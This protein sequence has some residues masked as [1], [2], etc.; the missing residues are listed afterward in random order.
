MRI[1]MVCPLD[2]A[3][4][5]TAEGNPYRA[6]G[7][8]AAA[9]VADGHQVTLFAAAGS[10]GGSKLV[11]CLGPEDKDLELAPMVR[12]AFQLA[13][14]L[15]AASTFDLVHNHIGLTAAALLS[16]SDLPLLT[17]IHRPCPP[18]EEPAWRWLGQDA[19]FSA[20]YAGAAPDGLPLLGMVSPGPQMAETCLALYRRVLDRRENYRPWGHYIVLE[21]HAEHKVKRIVVDPGQRLSLQLH[22]HRAEHWLVI[23]GQG[24]VTLNDDEFLVRAGEAIDIPREARHRVRNPGDVPCVFIEVQTGDYFG[25]DDIV[26]FEDDYGRSC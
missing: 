10:S 26:R 5:P 8:L 16:R 19:F 14:V 11:P 4:S 22:H 15:E 7:E 9:L 17:T 12:Q 13:S 20:S 2:R 18:V 23:E 24:L 21:D 25:E 1:A 3:V 6:I